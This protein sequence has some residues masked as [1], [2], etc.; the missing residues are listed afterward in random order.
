MDIELSPRDRTLYAKLYA[1]FS[2]VALARRCAE[3]IKAKGWY[4][5]PW[6]RGS[7]YFQQSAF[8]TSLVVSYSRPFSPGRGGLAFPKRLIPYNP[9]QWAL[10]DQLIGQRNEVYAHSDLERWTVRPWRSADF[11]TTIVGQPILVLEPPQI[12][13]FLEMTEPLMNA[14]RSRMDEIHGSHRNEGGPE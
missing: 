10:H 7:I 9:N 4:R 13:A 14:I 2:D 5:R 11:E 6:S 3:H 12:E 8:V 1:S